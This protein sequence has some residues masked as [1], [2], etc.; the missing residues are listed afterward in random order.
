MP[1]YAIYFAPPPSDPLWQFGSGVIGYDAARGEDVAF[2]ACIG[3]D[4]EAWAAKT[5]EP[6]RYGFHAT[7]KAPFELAA[8]VGGADLLEAVAALAGRLQSVTLPDLRVGG[9]GRFVA[10]VP[11]TTPADL[12]DFAFL[13][14]RGLDHL[15]APLSAHDRA[16]R[17][18][19]PLTPRQIANLDAYGYPYVADEFRFH[20][21]LTGP[22]DEPDRRVALAELAHGHA[23]LGRRT[24]PV[25]DALTVFRQ[26]T[27]AGRFRII[28]RLPLPRR[29]TA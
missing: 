7:L 29:P 28:A 21:T 1:R 20:M 27:R 14:V 6:R 11:E 3:T 26:E 23:D 8:G 10:L 22:L 24:P 19:S 5:E 2:P 12:Q 17:L 13:V 16:R 18:R 15:R 4:R 9:I 25:I